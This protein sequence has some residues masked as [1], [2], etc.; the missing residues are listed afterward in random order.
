M[1]KSIGIRMD[2]DFLEKIEKLSKEEIS[3]RSSIIRKL[4]YLGYKDLIKKKAAEDYMKGKITISEA[5]K[6]AEVTIWEI[7]NY[8]VEN[9]FKSSYSI[10]DLDNEIKLLNNNNEN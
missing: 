8:L 7:E 2:K 3:D 9:G 5:A 6:R 4:A 10:E 1:D